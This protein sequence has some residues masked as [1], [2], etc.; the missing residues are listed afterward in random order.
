MVAI[1][2]SIRTG[3]YIGDQIGVE[4][5]YRPHP[6]WEIRAAAVRFNTG[7]ALTQAGGKSIDFFMTNLSFRW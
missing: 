2:G 6:Q 7:E 5:G 3:R 4:D 1:L